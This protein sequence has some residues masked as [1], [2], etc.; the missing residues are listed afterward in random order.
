M[1]LKNILWKYWYKNEFRKEKEVLVY[2]PWTNLDFKGK[3]ILLVYET[4]W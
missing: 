3:D 4:W 2:I 1:S